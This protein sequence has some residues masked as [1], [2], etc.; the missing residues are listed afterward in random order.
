MSL[1]LELGFVG[2]LGGCF[3]DEE[4][5]DQLGKLAGEPVAGQASDRS[6]GPLTHIHFTSY[7]PSWVDLKKQPHVKMENSVAYL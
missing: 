3:L 5:K 4:V 6:L 2:D 1:V 7:D